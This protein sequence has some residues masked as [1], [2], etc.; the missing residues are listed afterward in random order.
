M[1]LNKKIIGIILLSLFVFSA[2]SENENSGQNEAS[3][4]ESGVVVSAKQFEFAG[5]KLGEIKPASFSERI[6]VTG[7]IDVPPN[8]KADVSVFYGGVVRNV[9]VL[10]GEKVKKGATL[11]TLENPDYIQ[12]QQDFLDYKSKLKYL[13][14]EYERQKG[15]LAENIT[16]KKKFM[17]AEAD[18]FTT[19]ANYSALYK[20]LRLIN[21]NPE[22]LSYETIRSEVRIP[23]PISGYVTEVNISKGEFLSPNETAVS[24]INTEHMHLELNIYEKDF[25]KIKKGQKVLFRLPDSKTKNFE[26]EIF[27]VG[28][29]V[30]SDNK[31][32]NV[33]AHLT[34][35]N[36]S[37]KFLPG[38]YVEG[39]ILV[40]ET[41]HP[42]LP[43]D[44]IVN[45]DE[46]NYILALKKFDGDKYIF[47]KQKVEI[48]LSNDGYTEIL[49]ANEIGG[50]KIVV[51]GAFNLIQ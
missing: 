26:A 16:S 42:A 41:E 46:E 28:K 31:A 19:L 47:E 1:K 13:K 23:A 30:T 40:G 48:G 44:A 39:E 9:N 2:C 50:K 51:K 43:S 37:E 21:V 22:N 38:M 18:Y 11:F 10:V 49:N 12:M 34:D 24:V 45:V 6:A 33:H 35:E 29:A 7:T 14:A 3:A 27:L 32:I 4:E 8:N 17:K 20:K 25:Y 15:L 5:M 36:Y